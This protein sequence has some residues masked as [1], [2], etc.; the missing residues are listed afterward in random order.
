MTGSCNLIWHV[1]MVN[2]HSFDLVGLGAELAPQKTDES[3]PFPSV[4]FNSGLLEETDFPSLLPL[5][6]QGAGDKLTAS[7]WDSAFAWLNP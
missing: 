5:N 7:R 4:R 2:Q 3:G 6:P 1:L